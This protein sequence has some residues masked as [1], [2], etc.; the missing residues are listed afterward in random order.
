MVAMTYADILR[1]A[2]KKQAAVYDIA[3]IL[4]GSAFIAICA[5]IA[6]G[7][8][9]PMTL[10]T[11]AVL[12]VG[13]LLGAKKGSLAVVIYAL[14]GMA[15]LPVFAGCKAG[16]AVMAGPTGGYIAGFAAAAYVVGMLCQRGWDRH[17]GTTI[18][19]M[20]VGEVIL[21]AFG[22]F[23]LGC[24]FGFSKSVLAMGFYPFILGDILKVALAAAVL[25]MGWKLLRK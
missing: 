16:M 10:Q 7:W 3:L 1:P 9:V 4:A 8:P 17:V 19:A 11:L 2:E 13:A 12:M 15:G 25:P 14:E 21:F 22:L 24:L 5:Q 18:A 23:W 6:V 20:V